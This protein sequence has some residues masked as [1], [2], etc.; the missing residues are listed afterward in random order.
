MRDLLIKERARRLGTARAL[1]GSKAVAIDNVAF[2]SLAEM[3]LTK[4]NVR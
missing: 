4:L 2:A 1:S 3:T